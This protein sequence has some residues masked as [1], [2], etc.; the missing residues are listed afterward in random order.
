MAGGRSGGRWPDIGSAK[1]WMRMEQA[2]AAR[3]ARRGPRQTPTAGTRELEA[4]GG[5]V[6]GGAGGG[7]APIGLVAARWCSGSRWMDK[8]PIGGG[9]GES[10]GGNKELKK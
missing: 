2:G 10:P 6:V 8:V 3:A 7:A 4:V 1:R 5:G 9:L